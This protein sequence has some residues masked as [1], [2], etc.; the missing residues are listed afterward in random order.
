[1][2]E[3]HDLAVCAKLEIGG[4]KLVYDNLNQLVR[5]M[6]KKILFAISQ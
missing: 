5:L 4:H 6:L 1:M 2:Y 3:V